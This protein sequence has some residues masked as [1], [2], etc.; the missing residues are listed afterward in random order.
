MTSPK[1]V[2]NNETISIKDIPVLPYAEFSEVVRSL[3]GQDTCHCVN[4]FA[5]PHGSGLKFIM[6]IADDQ[7][8]TIALLSYELGK[9]TTSLKS[10]T[11]DIPAL[12]GFEREIWE[13]Q[14]ITFEG[15]P[16]LKPIRFPWDRHDQSL[17]V[18][19]YPFYQIQSDQLHEV[20][21]GPIHAG[22]IEPGH[23]R[24]IC[25]GETVLHL[26]IQLGWQHR[27]TQSLMVTERSWL[28]RTMLAQNVAGDTAVGHGTAFCSLMESLSGI[29]TAPRLAVER[30]IALELER[31]AMHTLDLSA[32]CTD[33]AY[34]LGS[35]VFGV[36]R[37]PIINFTQSWCGN[38]VG[39][40]MSRIGGSNYPLTAELRTRLQVILADY[41]T[42]FLEMA[43][44]SYHMTSLED[45][46]DA[47]GR[48]TR[49]QVH[50]IGAVGMAAK[51]AGLSRDTRASHPFAGY[52]LLKF[53]PV[54]L[55]SGDVYARFLLRSK[56]IQQSLHILETLLAS[57]G[58]FETEISLPAEASRIKPAKDSFTIS[59]VEG[60]RGEICH[61]AVTDG[62][63]I[64]STYK[65]KD[66]SFHN[67][68][69]LALSL[70]DLEISDFP[71]NNKSYNLSYC[72]HDL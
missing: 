41:K 70:R 72:G 45:R 50:G 54:L 68:L 3:L 7:S 28:Q 16:W 39:K 9:E 20:G 52:G 47:I 64:L 59:L 33:I 13:D 21:V 44:H 15:H 30:T 71:I 1:T 32:L 35:A 36:L 69:A 63:G 48:L 66:P 22:V 56:E 29:Q 4:F 67:W 37:T 40:T 11:P 2:N 24:F 51:M 14:G 49:D 26:E 5:Y 6:A 31:I 25:N 34:Q 19:D 10:L 61:C 55:E 42:R 58:L 8:H 43:H 38:R 18:N 62:A 57:D 23:F 46:F 27:G 12:H 53:E 60:W 65:I 17:H